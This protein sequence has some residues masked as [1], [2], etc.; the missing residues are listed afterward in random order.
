MSQNS[1]SAE[2]TLGINIDGGFS[3]QQRKRKRKFT[4][5]EYNAKRGVQNK[6]STG[7]SSDNNDVSSEKN[8][9]N[10]RRKPRRKFPRECSEAR[11]E[12]MNAINEYEKL[13]GTYLGQ[14]ESDDLSVMEKILQSELNRLETVRQ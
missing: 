2:E 4:R 5:N 3:D 14:I 10:K 8:S 7:D 13:I 1:A 11:K 9:S 6:T 12:L